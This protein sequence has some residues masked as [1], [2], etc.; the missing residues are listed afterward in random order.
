MVTKEQLKNVSWLLK[1]GYGFY[2]ACRASGTNQF[3]E[4]GRELGKRR[5]SI[6]DKRIWEEIKKE[7]EEKNETVQCNLNCVA[8]SLNCKYRT[9]EEK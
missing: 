5:K 1:K 9:E 8:C 7:Q 4:V 2:E 6:S 3:S